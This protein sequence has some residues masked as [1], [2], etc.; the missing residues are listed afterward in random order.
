MEPTFTFLFIFFANTVAQYESGRKARDGTM[1]M[2]YCNNLSVCVC[3]C[4][5]FSCEAHF[6]PCS[7]QQMYEL[8]TLEGAV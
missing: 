2:N 1:I 8:E 5:C 4:V 3:V 7:L 6:P